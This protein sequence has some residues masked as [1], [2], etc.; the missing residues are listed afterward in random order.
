MAKTRGNSS[1]MACGDLLTVL[2]VHGTRGGG[3]GG[4]IL[5]DGALSE[6]KGAAKI[7]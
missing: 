6:G 7:G 1:R 2:V 5:T 4:D 3:G